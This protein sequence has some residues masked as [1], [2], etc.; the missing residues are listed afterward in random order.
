MTTD[1][2]ELIAS[3]AAA[4]TDRRLDWMEADVLSR[5]SGR[6]GDTRIARM[7]G[8]ARVATVGLASVIGVVLGGLVATAEVQGPQPASV[9]A[10]GAQLAPSTL[11]EGAG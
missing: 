8:P 9:F 7:A 3:L 11:L 10:A 5:I 1:L 6:R 4:P 2:D